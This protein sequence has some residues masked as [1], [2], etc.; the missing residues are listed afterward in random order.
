MTPDELTRLT[1]EEKDC[2][3]F[4][5][6]PQIN[7]GGYIQGNT[8]MRH[9]SG[10]VFTP[11]RPATDLNAMHEAEETLPEN[12]RY[13]IELIYL[14]NSTHMDERKIAHATAAARADAFLL[15]L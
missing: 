13:W 4:A 6:C 3:I 12:T 7:R 2:A 9:V 8:P 5:R 10:D 14:T 15:T 1:P 11:F